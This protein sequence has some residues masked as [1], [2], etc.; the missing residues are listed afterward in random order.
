MS[1][2]GRRYQCTVCGTVVLCTKAGEGA[3]L[4]DGE[5]MTL[6]QPKKLPSSD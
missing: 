4:C 2:L 6:Q 1:Q 5:E 3:V